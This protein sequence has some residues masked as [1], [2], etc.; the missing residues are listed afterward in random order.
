MLTPVSLVA[1]WNLIPMSP[2]L[3]EMDDVMCGFS[4]VFKACYKAFLGLHFSFL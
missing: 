2:V 3:F 4:S 1:F